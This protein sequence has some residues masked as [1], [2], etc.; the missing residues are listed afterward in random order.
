MKTIQFQG[1]TLSAIALGTTAFGK[2]Y[3]A[4]QAAQAI[5]Y[6]RSQ[7]V[8]VI[9]TAR[10][11]G[12]DAP[13]GGFGYSESMIGQYLAGR[14][15][16][17]QLFLVTKGAH[18][19]M[20]DRAFNR[21]TEKDLRFDLEESLKNLQTDYVDLYFLHRDNPQMD[22]AEVMETLHDFVKKGYVR[23]IGASNWRFKRIMEANAYAAE[24]GLTPFTASQIEWSMA[25]YDES[26]NPGDKT[27]YAM[28][29]E[30]IPLYRESG[31]LVMCYTSQASGLFSKIMAAG[32]TAAEGYDV[33]KANGG[34]M[35]YKNPDNRR[36]AIAVEQLCAKYG[37]SP[38]AIGVAYLTGMG[39]SVMPILG[40]SRIGQLEDS[41]SAPDLRLTEEDYRLIEGC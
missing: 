5:D 26:D 41:L 36:R 32:A 35:K 33:L 2:H 18:P 23:A 20:E 15:D 28:L 37:V 1:R 38:A 34:L 13:G 4:E 27:Q 30:E 21:L 22:M 7:G 9:D 24:H 8:N 39:S 6:V 10:V 40:S 12:F 14:S 17:D 3:S 19:P 16:R 11:Y 31:M 29:P 25:K